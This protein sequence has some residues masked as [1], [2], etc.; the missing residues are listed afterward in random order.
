MPEQEHRVACRA[1]AGMLALAM[2]GVSVGGEP[3]DSDSGTGRQTW[4]TLST[5]DPAGPSSA[6]A[7]TYRCTVEPPAHCRILSATVTPLA[8]P[9]ASLA[10]TIEP[11]GSRL[12]AI[13]TV[14]TPPQVAERKSIPPQVN[15]TAKLSCA[16]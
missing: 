4:H 1:T 12:T 2:I 6:G 8:S 11:D 10:V 16:T 7:Q 14:P 13:L 5:C 15:V 3:P 9:A